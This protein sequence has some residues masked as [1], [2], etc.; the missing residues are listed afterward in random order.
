[1]YRYVKGLNGKIL[2]TY[3]QAIKYNLSVEEYWKIF[4]FPNCE[5]SNN[6]EDLVPE[7][8]TETC[9]Y[10]FIK[11]LQVYE[12]REIEELLELFENM[13]ENAV[14]LCGIYLNK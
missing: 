3:K 14:L 8:F 13:P 4:S 5:C 6:L 1:M 12:E 10:S 11:G 9:D 7:L 2:D